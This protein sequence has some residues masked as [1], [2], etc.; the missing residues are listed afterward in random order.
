MWPFRAIYEWLFMAVYGYLV[1]SVYL[2]GSKESLILWLF[3]AIYTSKFAR[4]RGRVGYLLSI[5]NCL[6]QVKG[7]K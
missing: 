3:S 7:T 5:Q 6:L 1:F 2:K 4:P